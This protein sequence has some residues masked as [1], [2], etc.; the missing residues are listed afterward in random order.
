MTGQGRRCPECHRSLPGWLDR[1]PRWPVYLAIAGS[2]VYPGLRVM[3]VLGG[4]LGTMGAKTDVEPALA[5]SLI[6]LSSILVAFTVVLLVDRGLPWLRVLLGLGGVLAGSTLL[7]IGGLGTAMALSFLLAVGPDSTPGA[8]LS[9]WT[10]LAVYGSWLL[11]GFGVIAGSW[12]YW[13]HRREDCTTCRPL[14][15]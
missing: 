7:G 4:T 1:V 13:A 3:W 10:F 15:R 12:R 14:I 2:L 9:V 6:A 11:T 8:G 5:W